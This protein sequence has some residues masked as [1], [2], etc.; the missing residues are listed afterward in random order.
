MLFTRLLPEPSSKIL[1]KF[2]YNLNFLKLHI[3]KC[4]IIIIIKLLII[5]PIYI[6]VLIYIIKYIKKN[7][8]KIN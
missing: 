2:S 5:V 8:S 6:Y 4:N 7:K 1:S 3:N